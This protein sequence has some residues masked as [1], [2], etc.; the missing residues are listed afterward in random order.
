MDTVEERRG[1]RRAVSIAPDAH[2]SAGQGGDEMWGS[3]L[4]RCPSWGS[5]A[6]ACGVLSLGEWICCITNKGEN[7]RG[8]E[9]ALRMDRQT[10]RQTEFPAHTSAGALVSSKSMHGAGVPVPRAAVP[11]LSLPSIS[12]PAPLNPQISP[13]QLPS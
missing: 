5:M 6:R 11:E 8:R 3:S 12:T 1:H 7:R 2:H 9:S 13:S 10:D 4:G